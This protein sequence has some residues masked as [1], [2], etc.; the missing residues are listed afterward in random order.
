VDEIPLTADPVALLDKGEAEYLVGRLRFLGALELRSGDARFGGY[1][2]LHVTSDGV[3]LTALSDTGHTLRAVPEHDPAGRLVGLKSAKIGPLAGLDGRPVAGTRAHDAEALTQDG[4]DFV[5]GFEGPARIWHYP[6]GNLGAAPTPIAPPA[7]AVRLPA[8]AS[9]E[10]VA[11]IAPGRFLVMAEAPPA[12]GR[13]AAWI[14]GAVGWRAVVYVRTGRFVPVD[15]AALPNGDVIVLERR[16]SWAGGFATRIVR[17][18][19]VQLAGDELRGDALALIEP[20][21]VT[22]NFEG[23]AIRPDGRGGALLYL[24]SD[25]NFHPLQRTLLVL[26]GLDG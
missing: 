1:S 14:G 2:A 26:L 8:N 4:A 9:F 20:P 16:F 5:V 18:P 22:D 10:T 19:A 6:R 24:I 23:L 11:R 12:P 13:P 25:D 21:Y 7:E 15:A 3:G 17:V